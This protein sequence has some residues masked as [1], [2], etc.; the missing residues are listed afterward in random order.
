[1]SIAD[2]VAPMSTLARKASLGT[3]HI[4]LVE[5]DAGDAHLIETALGELA[6]VGLVD[7]VADGIE[8]LE[9]LDGK[10]APDIAIIDLQMPRMDGFKLLIEIGCRDGL[11]F[12]IIVLTSS[13]APKDIVRSLFR[14]ASHVIS[15]PDSTSEL[16]SVLSVAIASLAEQGGVGAAS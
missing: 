12:P 2:D 4:L 14:G 7:V 13:S 15:K 6:K 11:G 10:H 8:A 5:D 16:K 1:M 3:L 9:Y